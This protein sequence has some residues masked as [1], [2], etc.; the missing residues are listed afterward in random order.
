MSSGKLVAFRSDEEQERLFVAIQE[1]RKTYD[2]AFNEVFKVFFQKKE[3]FTA[4]SRP[5]ERLTTAYVVDV[6][7]MN[8]VLEIRR[9]KINCSEFKGT[10]EELVNLLRGKQPY[11]FE[12]VIRSTIEPTTI[13]VQV[14]SAPTDR[15]TELLIACLN[16]SAAVINIA[17]PVANLIG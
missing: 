7:A 5:N 11:E 17:A 4:A 10:F 8:I 9:R 6:E 16:V 15:S 2:E 14:S 3:G 13:Q 1:I 12:K